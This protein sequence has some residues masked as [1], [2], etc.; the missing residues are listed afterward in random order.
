MGSGR[1]VKLSPHTSGD[2]YWL[3]ALQ[4]DERT[5]LI[6]T[7]GGWMLDGMDVMIFTFVMPSLIALWHITRGQ[8][9][10]L[11]TS[12]L[13]V[14]SAGGWIAGLA[15]D[16]FGRVRVLQ[17]TIVWFALF[18]FLSGFTSSYSQL[19]VVRALQGLGFGGEWA[20]GAVLIGERV[21]AP[22]RGR[23]VGTTQ[24][25]WAVGWAMAA[26]FYALFFHL[27]PETVA[28][29]AMFF[30]GILP[31]A[32]AF[33]IRGHVREPE[34]FSSTQRIPA[35]EAVR[36]MFSP[37]MLR[38]IV[39][40][41][42]VALGAQG[43]YYAFNT[44]LPLYLQSRGLGVAAATGYLAVVIAGAFTGYMTSAH[45]AD[46]LG[47]RSS[48]VLFACGAFL[49][50]AA[51]LVLP[52]GSGA[53]LALGFP[54][55]FF[56]SGVFGPMGSFFSELFPTRLRASGQGFAYNVGRAAGACFPAAV[57]FASAHM[58]LRWAI[59]GMSMTAYAITVGAVLL[60]PETRGRELTRV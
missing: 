16:R 28:W 26:G 38:T 5:T 10:M 23:A 6:A 31:A 11:A 40:T 17:V 27:L 41:S 34:V 29:R 36:E 48:M 14:S 12:A 21:R 60:L 53:V 37:S 1:E 35:V 59:A 52:L 2:R 58:P 56:I 24:A 30:V 8:A 55:G 13:V 3:F 20:V 7:F 25:G 22:L 9:G 15:A 39:L 43:G 32:L 46:A 47:R 19:L 51:Y 33:W 49:A 54:A 44:F 50:L 45:M 4:R 57:G 42:T 18:T